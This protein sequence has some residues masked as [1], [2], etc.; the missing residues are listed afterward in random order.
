[1]LKDILLQAAF[2]NA[3]DRLTKAAKKN[4]VDQDEARQIFGA[5]V[6][7]HYRKTDTK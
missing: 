6:A 5:V 4:G 2:A 1:M 3:V 7:K